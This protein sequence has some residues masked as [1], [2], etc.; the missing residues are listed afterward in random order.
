V[1]TVWKGIKLELIE[2][3]FNLAEEF[4]NEPQYVM[5]NLEAMAALAAKMLETGIKPFPAESTGEDD[6][7]IVW[8]ELAASAINY[9]YWYGK[10]TVRP[11]GASST[12]MYDLI[13]QTFPDSLD[14]LDLQSSLSLLGQSLARERFPLLEE[15][16]RHLEQIRD[17]SWFVGDL[18]S[19]KGNLSYSYFEDLIV[20]F[21]GFGS[22]M[23][24]KRASL[25]FLQLYRTLGWFGDLMHWLPVPADYQVPK[26]LR[27]F[28]CIVYLDP[29]KTMVEQGALIPSGSLWECEIRAATIVVSKFLMIQTEWNV[30][31]IDSWLWL[32][33]KE[34]NDPFH[35]TVTTDY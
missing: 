3:V 16:I 30:S 6:Y 1:G 26:M 7:I 18:V 24:L 34:C 2:S 8:K 31:D 15:R 27:H 10:S 4:V 22:D 20:G 28:G 25:F 21:P 11:N 32:R 19:K 12:A 14:D 29:L 33:R 35:L 5:L 17:S 9:C 13:D 23:F